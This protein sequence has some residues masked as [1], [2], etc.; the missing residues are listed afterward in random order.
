MMSWVVNTTIVYRTNG[1]SSALR[2]RDFTL[3]NHETARTVEEEKQ[4]RLNYEIRVVALMNSHSI[5]HGGGSGDLA[6]S[7]DLP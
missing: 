1:I 3:I 4:S 2:Q 7:P 6:V 5:L